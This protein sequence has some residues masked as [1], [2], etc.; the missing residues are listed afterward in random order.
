MSVVFSFNSAQE[1]TN[2][3]NV[4][5]MWL[6]FFSSYLHCEW[7]TA[8]K[9]ARG[10][11][12]IHM[13]IKRYRA[14]QQN[15]MSFFSEVLCGL[16]AILLNYLWFLIWQV[17]IDCTILCLSFLWQLDEEPFNPD[18]VEVDRVLDMSTGVDPNSGEVKRLFNFMLWWN[19]LNI[20]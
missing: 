3:F 16:F 2:F 13:K 4:Y 14:K 7:A 12:R 1:N 11:K 8:E 20:Y 10:D 18:Y 9:L 6:H 19:Y 17:L 5:V 15:S